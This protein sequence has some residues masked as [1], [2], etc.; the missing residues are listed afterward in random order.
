M[1]QAKD[2]K[3]AYEEAKK[4]LL[5]CADENE[6]TIATC[7]I[8]LFERFILPN[9]YTGGCYLVTMTLSQ[10]LAK[11]HGIQARP[12][13]G[14]VNDT[15]DNIMISHA[16]LEYGGK[17]TD[18]TLNLTEHPIKPGPLLV[19]DESLRPG[20]LPY[21]YHNKRT[22]EGLIE[23]QRMMNDPDLAIIANRKEIEHQAMLARS[24]NEELMSAFLNAAPPQCNYN[25]MAAVMR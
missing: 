14:Y 18:L 13:V 9:A 20:L 1:G 8:A 7:A 21:T 17:K 12:V 5:S 15:T 19:L 2:R 16:W 4:K 6:K 22:I 24:H 11:E 10:F 23:V 25:A 3:R